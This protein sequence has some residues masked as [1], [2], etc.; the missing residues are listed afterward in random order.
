MAQRKLFSNVKRV[1]KKGVEGGTLHYGMAVYSIHTKF[2]ITIRIWNKLLQVQETP[3]V[4]T[5]N[6]NVYKSFTYRM[7]KLCNSS[8][9]VLLYEGIHNIYLLLYS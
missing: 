2:K 1:L 8:H 6:T 9:Q 4:F 3:I 7:Q 5:K